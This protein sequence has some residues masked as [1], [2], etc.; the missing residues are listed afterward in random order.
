MVDGEHEVEVVNE[1]ELDHK[2]SEVHKFE[3]YKDLQGYCCLWESSNVDYKN[4]HVKEKGKSVRG[5]VLPPGNPVSHIYLT[6]ITM[7]NQLYF[8]CYPSDNFVKAMNDV[9]VGGLSI[10]NAAKKWGLKR[11]TLQDRLSG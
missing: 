4:K 5:P 10:R 3:L 1:V 8:D 9:R 6:N 7:C 2:L 11:K